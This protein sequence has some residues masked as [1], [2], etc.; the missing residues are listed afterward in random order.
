MVTKKLS[1]ATLSGKSVG[2]SKPREIRD[3]PAANIN[4]AEEKPGETTKLIK[5]ESMET[6]CGFGCTTA[7]IWSQETGPFEIARGLVTAATCTH[8]L[9]L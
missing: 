8:G 5:K 7:I 1:Q 6:V 3:I 4:V 9:V 2:A